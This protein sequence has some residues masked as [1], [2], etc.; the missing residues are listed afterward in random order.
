MAKN[1]V[2]SNLL[3]AV[4]IGGGL[5]AMFTVKVEVFPEIDLDRILVSVVY[6]GAGPEDV[7]QGVVHPIEQAVDGLDGVKQLDS[8]AAEGTGTVVI[9]ILQGTNPDLVLQDIKS[10]VDRITTFPEEAERP[11]VRK[12]INQRNVLSVVVYGD[13][14]QRQLREQGEALRDGLLATEQITQVELAG[15]PE[16]EIAIEVSEQKLREYSL[17]LDQIAASVRAAS[18]DLPAGA[19]KSKDG[20]IMLRTKEKRYTAREYENVVVVHNPKGALVRLGDIASVRAAFAET[21]ESSLYDGKPAAIVNVF[22]VGDQTPLGIARAVQRYLEGRRH[23]VPEAVKFEVWNDRTEILGQRMRLLS[24]NAL[25]GLV[26]VIVCLGL[27]MRVRLAFWVTWGIPTAVLGAMIIVVQTNVS[28]NMI[29]L[30]AFIL[31]LGIV[32]DDAIVVGENAYT[33]HQMGK[34]IDDAVV[35]GTR[36]VGMPVTFSVLTTVAA[37]APLLFTPGIMGKFLRAIPVIVI[38][39]LLISLVESLFVLPAHLH[40]SFSKQRKRRGLIVRFQ[41]QV[42]RGLFWVITKP[43]HGTLRLAVKYRYATLALG[44]VSLLLTL[45]VVASGRIKRTF[46]PQLEGDVVRGSLV[47]PIGT[48]AEETKRHLERVQRIAQGL[49]AEYDAKLSK[50]QTNL[51]SVYSII[52]RQLERGGAVAATGMTGTNLGEVAVWLKEVGL[53]NIEAGVFATEWAKRVG[54][55]PGADALDFSAEMMRSGSQLGIQL[56]HDD[57]GVLRQASARLKEALRQYDGLYDIAD[58]YQEGKRELSLRL[59]PE[60]RALGLTQQGL[61]SQVRAAFYG[62]EALRLQRGRSEVKVM[63]RYPEG[64]RKNMADLQSMRIRTTAG[65]EIPFEQAAYV[66]EGRGYSQILRSKRKRVITVSSK[67]D[68]HVANP[69]EIIGDLKTG[70][71]AQLVSDYPGLTYDLEGQQKERKESMTGLA[72]GFLASLGL[73]FVLLAIPFRSYLQPLIIMTAIPFGI[74]G[75]I[76]GHLILG[77]QLSLFSTFGIVALTGVVVNDS[78]VMVDFINRQCQEGR[79]LID[80][81]MDAGQ[82]R[83]RPIM[84][85]TITTFFALVPMLAETSVQARF[86]IPMAISLA[87]GVLFSTAITLILVPVLYIVLEDLR[88]AWRWLTRTAPEQDAPLAE[89]EHK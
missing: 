48:S 39:V 1:H 74:I 22:R 59:R 76:I 86:L 4:L 26:L 68:E 38:S 5:L 87:C 64:E 17:T 80:A 70:A 88:K 89:G 77:Y 13:L 54:E 33:Y 57:Y 72:W 51:R 62:A 81:V 44:I 55:I 82:R 63:V 36:E 67:A 42:S 50:G 65:G 84:L 35:G 2:A 45:G 32:V 19:L 58:S 8:V 9:E 49:V 6:P 78:L 14:S 43:Y 46:M 47:M 75:A 85:T 73:I 40:K 21:D 53:R 18:L 28:I 41:D 23:E 29:S 30:F 71:L 10:A 69:E 34:S 27:F 25:Q 52:G 56:A 15:V 60:A 61:A 83:F 66:A 12:L 37:F 16:H 24:I 20:E 7:E 11:V 3:M 31:V 79:A